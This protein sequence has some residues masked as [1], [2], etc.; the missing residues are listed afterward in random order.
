MKWAMLLIFSGIFSDFKFRS[1]SRPYNFDG[2]RIE[3]ITFKLNIYRSES[4]RYNKL[5][6]LGICENLE[7]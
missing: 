5:I 7:L 4:S 3:I 1:I 2:R 6:I